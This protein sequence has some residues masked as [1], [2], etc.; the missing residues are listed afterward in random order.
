MFLKTGTYFFV[1]NREVKIIFLYNLKICF[2]IDIILLYIIRI[3]MN[4]NF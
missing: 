1:S 3:Y 2:N 4:Y